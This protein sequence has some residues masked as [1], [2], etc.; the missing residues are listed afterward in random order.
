MSGWIETMRAAAAAALTMTLVACGGGG[1]GDA[2]PP[3]PI[4][5][6]ITTQPQAAAVTEGQAASFNVAASGA[7][8]LA[9]Q[10]RRNGATIAG[11]TSATY[12][13]AAAT[14]ADSG[15]QFSVVVSNGAGSVT[16]GN[17]VLT[18]NAAIVA[19]AIATQPQSV[20]VTAG[21]PA[22]FS[23]VAT[24][25]APLA[26]QWRRNGVDIAGATSASY[27]T[28]ATTAGD[29][30]AVFTVRVSNAA[31]TAALSDGATL[32]VSA[33]PPT[34][35]APSITTQPQSASVTAGQPATF[36]VTA[37]GTPAPTYQWR[38]NGA[39]IAGATGASY[40]TPATTLA[41]NGAQFTVAVTNSAGS[42]TSEAVTLTVTAAPVSVAAA[43]VAAVPGYSAAR[44]ASGSV[45]TWG[46][47]NRGQL[48]DGTRT[49]RPLPFQ[50]TA[51]AQASAVS[52]GNS[53]TMALERSGVALWTGASTN[54]NNGT[55]TGISDL[56][57]PTRVVARTGIRA[58]A[59]G[60]GF[61]VAAL[62]DG[63]V[64]GWGALPTGVRSTSAVQLPGF[65]DITALCV[66]EESILALKRDGSV[67][68]GG[69]DRGGA[70]PGQGRSIT[71]AVT[72]ALQVSNLSDVVQIACGLGTPTAYA[73]A[74][75]RDGTVL[76]WG[77]EGG[78]GY[79]ITPG[80]FVLLTPQRVAGLTDVVWV[81]ASNT[82]FTA[83]FA[84]ASDGRVRSWGFDRL[85]ALALGTISGTTP[86]VTPTLSSAIDN[87][88]EVATSGEHTLFVLRDG[89]VWAV[90]SN[91]NGQLGNTSPAAVGSTVVPVQVLGVNL[92]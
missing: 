17:A 22:T 91:A 33:V 9:Y 36:T 76:S 25:T 70:M 51:T 15:A 21:Q 35:I 23:V 18:V 84:V 59:V 74:L 49:S 10:W 82:G 68:F 64:W 89:S 28:P 13:L 20:S 53:A 77:S 1:G 38:R 66:A 41:D 2:T 8:P 92:N 45:W 87:V 30:G 6:T 32:T 4:A 80:Q 55:G 72:I 79:A 43:R 11:A 39:D 65:T 29:S 81:A 47:N 58:I 12:T 90:G 7:A 37:T 86:V 75:R 42:V 27:T 31:P 14:L 57:V 16:S 48:G 85:G 73:L 3:A 83:S 54:E 62:S 52:L 24:G 46:F 63:T 44:S 40:T 60:S 69:T 50:W 61:T 5:P 67:W 19:P 78:L 71:T 34:P 26:Y 88:A 56:L